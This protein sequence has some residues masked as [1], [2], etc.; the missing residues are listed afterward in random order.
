MIKVSVVIPTHNSGVY[1]NSAI[2]S[3]LSQV[4]DFEIIV[5]D[6]ASTDNTEE[7]VKSFRGA[8]IQYYR[9]ESRHGGPSK[10][11]NIGVRSASGE[12]IAFLDSDDLMLP[13]RLALS[14]R[15]LDETPE[16]GLVFSDGLKF[17][18]VTGVDLGSFLYNYSIF[19]N[20]PKISM[21]DG[22]QV[23]SAIDAFSALF[24]TNYIMPSGVTVRKNIII[25]SGYFDESL[26]NGDDRDMWFRISRSN[27]IGY[28]TD[29]L[30]RY[31]VRSGSISMRGPIL[32]ENR[33][34]VF[35]K[36]LKFRLDS[37]L[38]H[39][40]LRMI[41]LNLAGVGYFYRSK[42]EME[43]ACLLFRQ[44]IT[45]CFSWFA[46]RGYI[47]SLLHIKPRRQ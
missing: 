24:Y 37:N 42:G 28:L 12:Y 17:D 1:I 22:R 26:T 35:R 31:R 39:Q 18:D 23:I 47:L 11:R 3:V 36:Q 38:E 13:Q 14:S 29:P 32:A 19:W 27:S 25:N 7:I 4:G 40:A 2:Q 16:I 9:L 8:P 10:P 20:L 34:K 43:K 6:D 21:G 30:F 44:A 33:I 15:Y 41:S 46:L 45:E 5:V